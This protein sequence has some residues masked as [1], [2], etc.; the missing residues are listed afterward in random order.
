MGLNYYLRRN[1]CECCKRYDKTHI[2]KSSAGY[3]FLFST[4]LGEN[5]S[6]VMKELEEYKDDIVDEFGDSVDLEHL[7]TKIDCKQKEKSH[8]PS[9]VF[10]TD[11]DGYDFSDYDFS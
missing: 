8:E 2:G 5:Y 1:Y 10:Y 9:H 11:E 7:K 4:M 6:E 3:K